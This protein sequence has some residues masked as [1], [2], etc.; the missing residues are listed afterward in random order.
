MPVSLWPWDSASMDHE[1]PQ[2]PP[3]LAFS[4][5]GGL[6]SS[7]LIHSLIPPLLIAQVRQEHTVDWNNTQLCR[8]HCVMGHLLLTLAL[9]CFHM[10]ASG[11]TSLMCLILPFPDARSLCVLVAWYHRVS[12]DWPGSR[13][14]THCLLQAWGKG[15]LAQKRKWVTNW[16][17]GH[18]SQ[19]SPL[20]SVI[21]IAV[22]IESLYK[23][24]RKKLARLLLTQ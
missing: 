2:P 12:K 21:L 9:L 18:Y 17:Y 13:L 1:P 19:S 14:S 24:C 7:G 20:P 16:I 3:V 6:H 4:L 15:S 11:V 22:Q 23:R 5:V 8:L 10:E